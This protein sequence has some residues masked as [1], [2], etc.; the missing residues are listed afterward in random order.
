LLGR[1]TDFTPPSSPS[2]EQFYRPDDASLLVISLISG[3]TA[4]YLTFARRA[5][6]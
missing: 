6:N 5:P 4:V 3:F 1:I 2:V